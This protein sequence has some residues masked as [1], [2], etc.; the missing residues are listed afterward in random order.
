MRCTTVE[1]PYYERSRFPLYS[2]RFPLLVAAVCVSLSACSPQ[3]QPSA[4]IIDVVVT[5]WSF[6]PAVITV[7]KGEK[8]QLRLKGDE[9]IHSLLVTDLGINVRVE[10]DAEVIVD[11]PTDVAGTFNGRC[12]VPCGSGHR[13]MLLTILVE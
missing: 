13:D 1:N 11:I 5:D 12:G 2:M 10:A 8:V 4:R 9:G 7:K 6:T 3:A